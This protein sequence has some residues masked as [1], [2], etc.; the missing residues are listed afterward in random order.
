MAQQY[1]IDE[2]QKIKTKLENAKSI[3]LVDYKGINIE[4][5]NELRNRFRNAKVDYFI[6]K[7][8][9]IKIA[10]NDL[11]I[12]ELDSYLVGPTAIAACDIDEVAPAR[13][14]K[15]FKKEIME[16]KDFP[17]FKVGFVAGELMGADKLNQLAELPSKEVLMSMVLQG[18]NAPISGL[19][20]VL[21]G[22][23]RKFVYAVDAVAKEKK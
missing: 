9:F 14:L 7:N 4:E 3:I 22:V 10:L 13:E 21:Q 5:V 18:F 17:Q 11:G 16:D 23:L 2:V 12:T 6:S 20:G 19:V 1:K 15:K 8:T